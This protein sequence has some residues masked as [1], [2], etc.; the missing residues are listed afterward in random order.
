V[1]QAALDSSHRPDLPASQEELLLDRQ[2]GVMA[3]TSGSAREGSLSHV[4]SRVLERHDP[5]P[6]VS[7]IMPCHNGQA[8]V[9]AAV[10]SVLGQTYTNFEILAVD[11][12]ST[13]DTAEILRSLAAADPR[14]ITWSQPASG[15]AAAARNAAFARARGELIAFLDADDLYHPEK[16]ARA[17]IG[18]SLRSDIQMVF[19]DHV[20]FLHD[21]HEVGAFRFLATRSY[22]GAAGSALAPVGPNWYIATSDFYRFSSLEYVGMVTNSVMIRRNALLDEP[23]VFQPH[24]RNGEDVDLWLR[25]IHRCPIAYCD[26]AL[27]YYRRTGS[28]VSSDAREVARADV[29]VHQANLARGQGRF[30]AADVHRYHGKIAEAWF[31]LG[32]AEV[33]RG[34]RRAGRRAYRE[35]LRLAPSARV[36]AALLKSFVPRTPAWRRP[37]PPR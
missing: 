20:R 37:R 11:D 4:S 24:L 1:G 23:V 5:P 36:L 9:A 13:D 10:E 21:P 27:S 3:S 16:L 29:L 34:H 26:E 30:T 31:G 6:I 8:H 15:T 7:V 33:R 22:V 17:L 28:G 12:G 19:H 2:T 32:Y 14:V 35:A 25:L 18:F